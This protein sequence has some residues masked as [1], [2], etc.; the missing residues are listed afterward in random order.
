MFRVAVRILLLLTVVAMA[1]VVVCGFF[2]ADERNEVIVVVMSG[3]E[4]TADV[5]AADDSRED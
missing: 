4:C 5:S 3:G 1:R 2:Q